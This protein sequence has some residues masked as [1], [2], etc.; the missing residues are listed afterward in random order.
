VIARL[1]YPRA[2]ITQRVI[3]ATDAAPA[4]EP[5]PFRHTLLESQDGIKC[6]LQAQAFDT[7][8]TDNPRGA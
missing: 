7:A 6:A 5:A 3:E 8:G 1:M 2:A 4:K